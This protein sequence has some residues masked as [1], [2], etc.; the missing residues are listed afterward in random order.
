M[1]TAVT[2]SACSAS[3]GQMP[4]V[5]SR[6]LEPA[7]TAEAR[8]SRWAASLPNAWRSA[9]AICD[10]RPQRIGQ[11]AGERQPDTAAA[12]NDNVVA[13]AWSLHRACSLRRRAASLTES[14]AGSPLAC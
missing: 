11:R 4:S 10:R 13:L 14:P 3:G 2:G 6:R 1:S 9:T 8:T 5:A 7:E 12:G